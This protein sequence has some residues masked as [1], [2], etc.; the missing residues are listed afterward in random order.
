MSFKTGKHMLYLMGGAYFLS[1]VM[2]EGD[3]RSQLRMAN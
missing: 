3:G 2:V 1:A